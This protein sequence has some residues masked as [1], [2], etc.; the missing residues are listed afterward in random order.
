[1]KK[2]LLLTLVALGLLLSG[3]QTANYRWVNTELGLPNDCKRTFTHKETTIEYCLV[4]DGAPGKWHFEG[5]MRNSGR[6]NLGH[7][8]KGEIGIQL[9][10]GDDVVYSSRI[11]WRGTEMD[12]P[13]YLYSDFEY[14][15]NFDRLGFWWSFSYR[16]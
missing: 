9:A 10:N 8:S 11:G 7:I 6:H 3:C 13:I 1:M 2:L 4:E 15:G 14:D 12:R 16:K 5:V